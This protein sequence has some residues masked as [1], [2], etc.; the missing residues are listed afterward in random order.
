[1][2]RKKKVRGFKKKKTNIGLNQHGGSVNDDSFEF[3]VDCPFKDQ[4]PNLHGS[5]AI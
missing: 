1:M 2:E 5:I 3:G 4:A